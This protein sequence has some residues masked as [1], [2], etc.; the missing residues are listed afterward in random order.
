MTTVDQNISL[1]SKNFCASKGSIKND[2]ISFLIARILQIILPKTWFCWISRGTIQ[3]QAFLRPHKWPYWT[4][5]SDK[6]YLGAM[7]L[8]NKNH[9]D[10]IINLGMKAIL[11]INEDYELQDQLCAKPVKPKDWQERNVRV[12]NIS[13]PDLKPIEISK[14]AQAINYV[15]QEVNL[16]NSVYVHCTSGRGRSASVVVGSLI[17]T[18]NCSLEEAIRH[19]Q[20]CRPQVMLSEKQKEAIG[21]CCHNLSTRISYS[22]A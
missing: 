1:K 10:K 2:S 13:S 19:V 16:G 6:I 18:T 20:K 22:Y 3:L 12:L 15:V 7:P 17:Q 14:L 9:I 8:K 21:I 4:K 11:S 5:I